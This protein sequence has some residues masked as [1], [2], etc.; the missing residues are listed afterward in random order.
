MATGLHHGIYSTVVWLDSGWLA[1]LL[2][3]SQIEFLQNDDTI[4]GFWEEAKN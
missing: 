3:G 1:L 4:F 2:S